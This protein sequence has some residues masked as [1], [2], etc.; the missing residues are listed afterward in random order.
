MGKTTTTTTKINTIHIFVQRKRSEKKSI[1]YTLAIKAMIEEENTL[2][3]HK[4]PLILTHEKKCACSVH[5]CVCD[6]RW[7]H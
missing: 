7:K 3:I 4:T 6:I 1:Q 5:V 2:P